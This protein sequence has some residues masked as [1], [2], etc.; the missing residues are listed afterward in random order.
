MGLALAKAIGAPD[1]SRDQMRKAFSVTGT[2][3]VILV[4]I[5]MQLNQMVE[6]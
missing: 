4:F 3:G 6:I 5:P 1:L 2:T